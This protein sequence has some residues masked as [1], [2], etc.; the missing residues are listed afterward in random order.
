MIPVLPG[1]PVLSCVP[2]AGIRGRSKEL[3]QALGVSCSQIVPDKL[4]LDPNS[5]LE[6]QHPV[7]ILSGFV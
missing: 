6:Q 3:G 2:G 5:T 1:P 7:L 4:S